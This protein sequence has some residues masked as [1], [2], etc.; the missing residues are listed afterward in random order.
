MPSRGNA[1]PE[2]STAVNAARYARIRRADIIPSSRSAAVPS[3]SG[4][5]SRAA[6]VPDDVGG[7]I[8]EP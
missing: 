8:G 2:P 4:A 7:R 6:L 1:P 5:G 3:D